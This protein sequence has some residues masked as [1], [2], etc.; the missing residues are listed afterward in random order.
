MR[1]LIVFRFVSLLMLMCL[2]LF[3]HDMA[4][5]GAKDSSSSD[6]GSRIVAREDNEVNPALMPPVIMQRRFWSMLDDNGDAAL[7]KHILKEP[8]V[9][10]AAKGYTIPNLDVK[11]GDVLRVTA[12]KLLT[13]RPDPHVPFILLNQAGRPPFRCMDDF[14][15]EKEGYLQWKRAHPNFLGFWTGVEWENEYISPLIHNGDMGHARTWCSETALRRMQG[16]LTPARVSRDGAVEGLHACYAALRRYFFDDPDKMLF[17]REFWCVDHPTLEWGAGMSIMETTNTGLYRHQVSMF[18]ARGAARQYGKPWQWY[19]AACYN[20]FDENGTYSANN[21]A[22]YLPFQCKTCKDYCWGPGCGMSVSL[23]RR[24]MYLAYLSGASMVDHENWVFHCC[25]YKDGNPKE[26]VLSPHGEAMKE[27]YTFTQ[28]H[29]DRGVSY[30]PVAL[31]LPFNQ[32]MPLSGGKPW[33]YFAA[34][35][36]DTMIDAFM[37]TIVPHL[38][39]MQKGEEGCLFNS[40]YGDIYDVLVPNPPSGPIPLATLMNYKVAIMLGKFD[41]DAPLADRLMEYVRQGG[42]LV[43]NSQQVNDRLS[44]EFLGVKRTGKSVAAEGKVQNMFGDGSVTLHE[45]YD[46]EQVTLAGAKRMWSDS[47]GGT[48]ASLNEYGRGRVV[49]T[50]AD[51]M[52]PSKKTSVAGTTK[53]RSLVDLL[54]RQVVTEVLP[55]EFEGDVEYGMCKVSDGWWMYLINNKGVAKF[56]KTPESLNMTKTAKVT[57]NLRD[58]AVA[59]MRE[60]RDDKEIAKEQGKNA[61]VIEVGP[62]DIR[63]VKITLDRQP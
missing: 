47:K 42:T 6:K 11:D 45:P 46:Y 62:G 38:Q 56:T 31:L 1:A 48:L 37:Y 3:I 21:E 23:Y 14:Q 53:K 44:A 36:P 32:G 7:K 2:V 10:E 39:D 35:R 24:D 25:Q 18:N 58:L 59:G 50:T 55:I 15:V 4:V 63:V 5:A 27:W 40:E 61:F 26:W 60:L 33:S 12:N 30:A 28:R 51:Y 29:S 43:I 57:V 54:M 19:I 8:M 41:I 17:I 16:V 20:G 49:L 22:C 9:R 13:L 52:V 34:E